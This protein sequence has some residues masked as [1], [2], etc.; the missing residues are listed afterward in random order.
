MG[1][2]NLHQADDLRIEIAG[3]AHQAR[4]LA[5]RL[6]ANMFA[7]HLVLA[8]IVGF[9]AATADSLLL[10][11]GVTTVSVLGAAALNLLELFVASCK[12]TFS[13][14]C[15]P[16]SSAW[17]FTSIRAGPPCRERSLFSKETIHVNRLS[18]IAML[19]LMLL[20]LAA[21]VLA[22]EAKKATS[23]AAALAAAR[24]ASPSSSAARSGP[25]W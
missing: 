14:F 10:W 12:P 19:C 11:I 20:L 6:F 2:G 13:R 15:R 3:P 5:V 17:R 22:P 23:A 7:G 21:P 1:A 16:C 25:G 8:V 18:R 24:A 9:I 4:V